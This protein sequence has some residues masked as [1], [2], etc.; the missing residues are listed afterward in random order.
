MFKVRS[1][2][3]QRY[4]NSD[5]VVQ[6][7]TNLYCL[8]STLSVISAESLPAKL[9][10]WQV[11]SPSSWA[12]VTPCT[13]NTLPSELIW[14]RPPLTDSFPFRDQVWTGTGSPVARHVRVAVPPSTTVTEGS[15]T[16]KSGATGRKLMNHI[17]LS[18]SFDL[19]VCSLIPRPIL[20]LLADI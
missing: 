13:V 8:L 3:K 5:G 19:I 4:D 12:S 10:A 17:N 15:A 6:S 1:Y 9:E 14:Y 20:M 11:N 7:N 2:H 16:D 18:N